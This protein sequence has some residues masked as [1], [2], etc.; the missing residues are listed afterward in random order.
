M[1]GPVV[2]WDN[3]PAEAPRRICPVCESK[4][5]YEP[6]KDSPCGHVK[7]DGTLVLP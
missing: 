3:E 7:K 5:V 4:Y 1:A 6:G 2:A